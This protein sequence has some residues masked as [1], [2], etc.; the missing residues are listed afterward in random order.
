MFVTM[1]ELARA[2]EPEEGS[3]GGGGG[4]GN[5]SLSVLRGAAGSYLLSN[6]EA[7]V[8][9]E[10]YVSCRDDLAA[11]VGERLRELSADL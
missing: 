6:I 11:M 7:L 3:G 10:V 1:L 2:L 8:G 9:E 5:D 4:G